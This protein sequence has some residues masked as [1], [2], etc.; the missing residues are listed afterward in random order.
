M[1]KTL[2]FSLILLSN[3]AFTQCTIIDVTN[4]NTTNSINYPIWVSGISGTQLPKLS[5]TKIGWN[6]SLPS[7]IIGTP[8][9]TQFGQIELNESRNGD[10]N[11]SV[12]N[13]STGTNATSSLMAWSN[14]ARLD[15]VTTGSGFNL[16]PTTLITN[17]QAILVANGASSFLFGCET[18]NADLIFITGGNNPEN[19]R[20]RIDRNGIINFKNTLATSSPGSIGNKFTVN[21]TGSASYY[22]IG[23]QVELVAGYTGNSQTNAARFD[24]KA[25]GTGSDPFFTG[26]VNSGFIATAS[27]LTTGTNIAT[28]GVC[29]NGNI[30]YGS[31]GLGYDI[32]KAN[33]INIGVAGFSTNTGTS[34]KKIGGYFGLQNST[35]TFV[36]AALIADNGSSTDPVFLARINGVTKFSINALG[37]TITQSGVLS[38]TATDGFLYIPTCAGTPTGIPTTQTG[39]APLIIDITNGKL[40]FYSGSWISVN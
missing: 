27:G 7:L 22:Q 36:S 25:C 38:T 10:E 17:N 23:M 39:T 16:Y 33:S 6:P 15:V 5:S 40:Y 32:V 29:Y 3:F 31:L 35:P 20:I 13:L 14:V 26:N 30:N 2:I 8:T 1:K 4:D 18:T 11:I 24:N 37:S 21:S 28:Y 19:E 12:K 34:S 9:V